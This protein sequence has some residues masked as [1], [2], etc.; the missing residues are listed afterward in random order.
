MAQSFQYEEVQEETIA[1]EERRKKKGKEELTD[2]DQIALNPY[3]RKEYPIKL[4]FKKVFFSEKDEYTDEKEIQLIYH[5]VLPDYVAGNYPVEMSDCL[6][7]AAL[8]YRV[9]FG[10]QTIDT[11]DEFVEGHIPEIVH[12]LHTPAKWKALVEAELTKF[13]DLSAEAARADFV[14]YLRRWSQFGTKIFVCTQSHNPKLPPNI[15]IGVDLKGIHLMNANN[16]HILK[17]I[18]YSLIFEWK[19]SYRGVSI[20]YGTNVDRQHFEASTPFGDQIA[21]LITTHINRLVAI[22]KKNT[23]GR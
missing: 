5:Q 10:Q 18:P 11:F 19:P 1:E 14:Q 21:D 23:R 3:D 20:N 16:K 13:P 6:T 2:E 22:K 12:R 15:A 17:T 7:L 4:V 8:A 9:E